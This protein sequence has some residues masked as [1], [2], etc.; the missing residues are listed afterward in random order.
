MGWDEINKRKKRI[1]K[2][3]GKVILPQEVPPRE[4]VLPTL[5]KA[6]IPEVVKKPVGENEEVHRAMIRE[7]VGLTYENLCKTVKDGL[8]AMVAIL[9]SEGK[10][11]NSVPSNVERAK[12]VQAAI[13][14]LGAKKAE[15]GAQK[16]P[17][18]VIVLP[19]GQKL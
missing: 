15:A 6:L 19:S 12:F 9:D 10:I 14:L 3:A 5:K 1:V 7:R 16:C 4:V 11:V 2:S 13:D 18:I 8:E 17:S